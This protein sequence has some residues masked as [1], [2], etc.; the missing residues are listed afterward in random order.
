MFKKTMKLIYYQIGLNIWERNLY[1]L[2]GA[3]K[4]KK[5]GKM[6]IIHSEKDKIKYTKREV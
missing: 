5:M 4:V 6:V 3:Q 1:F 2:G